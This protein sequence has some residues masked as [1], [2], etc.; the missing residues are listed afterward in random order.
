M[1]LTASGRMTADSPIIQNVEPRDTLMPLTEMLSNVLRTGHGPTMEYLGVIFIAAPCV[2]TAPPSKRTHARGHAH[3]HT[4]TAAL[5]SPPSTQLVPCCMCQRERGRYT[6]VNGHSDREH[7]TLHL[8]GGS[9]PHLTA[10]Y[11]EH[12]FKHIYQCGAVCFQKFFI[13]NCSKLKHLLTF[14]PP[15]SAHADT[16]S[17]SGVLRCKMA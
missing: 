8:W 9:N 4:R 16:E 13:K 1:L 15:L 12:Y 7:M 14:S 2:T 17:L 3:T 11:N 5:I 6:H 10:S